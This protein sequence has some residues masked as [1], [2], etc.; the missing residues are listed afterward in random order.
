MFEKFRGLNII[1]DFGK[2]EHIEEMLC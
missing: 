2:E 1:V